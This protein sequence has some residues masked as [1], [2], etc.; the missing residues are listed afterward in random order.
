LD[1]VVSLG[2]DRLA[3]YGYAHVPHV[4]KRQVM[5][6]S[7]AL[8]GPEQRFVMS[9]IARKQ[10]ISFGYEPIGLDHFALPHD[11]LAIAARSNRMTRNFQGY[12]DDPCET[13]LGF[14]ASAISK[15]KQGFLQNAVATSAYQR[16]IQSDRLAA[17]KG[18]QLT[19]QDTFV[20]ALIDGVM[21]N[22]AIS[23]AAILD[24]FPDRADELT[25]VT[26]DLLNAFPDL[27]L[28]N[29]QGVSV[30]PDI[31]A[32]ARLISAHLDSSRQQD[33]IHSLAV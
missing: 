24:R 29:E 17:H 23:N 33:H 25:K 4:S 7:D 26:D 22:G 27:L 20:A 16:R 15:F 18:Y 19:S 31:T 10:L 6:D 3:L 14:G 32:A 28:A 5:I 9:Q 12:T 1:Q 2:P 21:C 30:R 8:P 11:S 13:L